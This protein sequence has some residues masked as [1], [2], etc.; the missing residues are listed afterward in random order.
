MSTT[1]ATPS[2]TSP[3]PH[4]RLNVRERNALQWLRDWSRGRLT[5]AKRRLKYSP[6]KATFDDREAEILRALVEL[7]RAAEMLLN[8]RGKR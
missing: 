6:R 1:P 7:E 5:V 3:A 2:S 8:E 4:L